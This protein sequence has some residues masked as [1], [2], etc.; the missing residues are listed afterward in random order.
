MK[1]SRIYGLITLASLALLA[2]CGGGGSGGSGGG[3]GVLPTLPPTTTSASGVLVNHETGAAIAGV[4]VAIA[5]WS[6]ANSSYTTV[7]TTA[8]DG[9]FSF[10][11]VNG[12]YLL[13]IG[14]DSP[15]DTVPTIH[16]NITLRGGTQALVA[17]NMP[18]QPGVTM[19]AIEA[20]GKYRLATLSAVETECWRATNTQRANAGL[21]ALVEDEWLLENA[22]AY[23]QGQVT[24]NQIGTS[25]AMLTRNTGQ[26]EGYASCTAFEQ[27]AFTSGSP[28]YSIVTN[29]ALLWFGGDWS[30]YRTPPDS[31]ETQQWRLNP[32][33][34]PSDIAWI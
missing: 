24:N 28:T 32:R 10:T 15:S 30:P 9:S 12:Q 5:S 25:G 13:R 21:S 4:P 2:A 19:P 1:Q 3:G 14:S 6:P 27:G 11:A 26:A 8:A 16:D 33:N 29:P 20:S 23:N 22:R 18:A 7:A 34:D 17:P 31:L